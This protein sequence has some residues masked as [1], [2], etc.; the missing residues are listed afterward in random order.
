MQLLLSKIYRELIGI[1]IFIRRQTFYEVV[2]LTNHIIEKLNVHQNPPAPISYIILNI[3]DEETGIHF[4]KHK[5]SVL[6]KKE[7]L[8]ELNY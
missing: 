7:S 3:P 6:C 2:A 8:D 1:N 4:G 5:L